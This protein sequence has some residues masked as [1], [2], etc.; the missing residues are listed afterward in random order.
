LLRETRNKNNGETTMY[1][2]LNFG[3]CLKL[4]LK[5]FADS[6]QE[7]TEENLDK[8]VTELFSNVAF[9]SVVTRNEL[10][11][12]LVIKGIDREFVT[13]ISTT[14]LKI[15]AVNYTDITMV[16]QRKFILDCEDL[17]TRWYDQSK[18]NLTRSTQ[19]SVTITTMTKRD[20]G[21]LMLGVHQT[22]TKMG[23]LPLKSTMMD[24]SKSVTK[25]LGASLSV[26]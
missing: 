18:D 15:E 5:K 8:F 26:N 12:H 21:L 20:I 14:L 2:P 25:S 23:L 6:K 10:I 3:V 11:E 16:T 13:S 9:S 7:A 1:I 17:M 24:T 4:A 22:W 19:K